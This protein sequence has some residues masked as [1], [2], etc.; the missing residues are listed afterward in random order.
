MVS[1]NSDRL[2]SP[3]GE[4]DPDYIRTGGGELLAGLRQQLDLSDRLGLD[5]VSIR[6]AESLDQ[7]VADLGEDGGKCSATFR[8][9][10]H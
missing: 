10:Q 4:S 9:S 3:K 5:L 8:H 6:I 2:V 7:L 1:V